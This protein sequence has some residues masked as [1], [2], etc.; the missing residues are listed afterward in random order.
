MMPDRVDPRGDTPGSI[1]SRAHRA[2][3]SLSA[4]GWP[5]RVLFSRTRVGDLPSR[6]MQR[7][8]A[9]QA[10]S[11]VLVGWVQLAVVVFLGLLYAISPKTFSAGSVIEPVPWALGSYF[12]FTV[13]RLARARR[14]PLPGW[15]AGL[16]CIV[17]VGLLLLL[18]W[19]FHIQYE[20]PAAFVLKTPTLFYAFVFI[21]LRTLLLEPR[22][23]VLTGL[24]AAGGWLLTVAAV[25]LTDRRPGLITRS[26]VEYLTSSRVLVGAEIDKVVAILL[27]TGLLAAAMLRGR[28]LLIR[29]VS[30]EV[31][32]H[33]LERFFAR[34]VVE[35]ITAGEVEIVPGHG[36]G[37]DA[38]ILYVD[39]RDFTA[40]AS[41]MPAA[42]LIELLTE[43]QARLVPAVLAHGGTAEKYLGDGMMAAFGAVVK[44][45]AY[46]ADALRAAEGMVASAERWNEERALAGRP[47][48]GLRIAITVGHIVAGAVGGEARLEYA[49]V[50][51]PVNVAAKLEKH[52]KVAG[53][54]ILCTREAYERAV[55]QGWGR[56]CPQSSS[57]VPR[58]SACP[59][60]W[61]SSSWCAER[62]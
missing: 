60:R 15:L 38:A 56:P 22:L 8:R 17:D 16:S 61:T 20:Q 1:L 35:R 2:R 51:H 12:A 54:R 9:Q 33:D 29:S 58:S 49:V 5:F 34:E 18:I 39:I 21:A 7:V 40:M 55:E 3:G 11:D 62:R 27:V 26:Y 19:S 32:T 53:A 25:V 59:S 42:A 48:I 31:K 28:T 46:A 10:V 14:G 30:D 47:L 6:V 45:E 43:Y 23:V 57:R 41:A 44:R 13:A 36:E 4:I 50:G 52:A 37:R 24:A